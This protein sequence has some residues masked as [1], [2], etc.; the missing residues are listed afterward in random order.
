MNTS[1]LDVSHQEEISKEAQEFL[2]QAK[3][4]GADTALTQFQ[5]ELELETAAVL[6]A[7]AECRLQSILDA[8]RGD[9]KQALF[10]ACLQIENLRF[11]Q[12][13]Q[14]QANDDADTSL[15]GRPPAYGPDSCGKV[16]IKKII[17]DELAKMQDEKIG[18]P[19]IR[20]AI[21]RA[22]NIRR[23]PKGS[24]NEKK[25]SDYASRYSEANDYLQTKNNSK[26]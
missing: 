13:L 25:I 21:S 17:A 20:D 11:K 7:A 3:H 19:K 12:A 26:T 14:K 24:K 2:D 10:A 15:S 16:I 1:K 9:M 23:G 22:Y 4:S 18:K 6:I 5:D 8:C